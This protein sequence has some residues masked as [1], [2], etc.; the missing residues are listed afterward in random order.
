MATSQALSRPTKQREDRVIGRLPSGEEYYAPLGE[1]RSDG[2]RVQCHLCGRWFKMVGG[3]HLLAAH[4]WTTAEYREAFLLN[5]TASTIG[6]S[7]HDRKRESMLEQID[8]GTRKYPVGGGGPATAIGWRSLAA[9]RP[10]VA[11]D[12]HPTRNRAIEKEGLTPR[13]M[14]P[15]STRAVWWCC[16]IC[17]HVWLTGI[18]L[19]CEGAGCPACYKSALR[20]SS[21]ALRHPDLATEWHPTR[22]PSF[23]PAVIGHASARRVWWRCRECGHEW[24]ATVKHRTLRSQGCPECGKRRLA[25]YAASAQRWRVPR[26]KSIG[27]RH[28]ELLSEWHP[29]RNE[30]LDPFAVGTGSNLRVWWQCGVCGFEWDARPGHRCDGAG[31]P[32]CSP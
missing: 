3:N 21:L 29:D 31:C 9:L 26:D 4:G 22:N 24:R 2:G 23:D 17:K 11:V 30:G 32:R 16:Q 14:G 1:M 27:V 10:E 25:E 6:A 5:A 19:R 7:T 28:P 18:R 8:R 15:K 12:W 20:E 13:T